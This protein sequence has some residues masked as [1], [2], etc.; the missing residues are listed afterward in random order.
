[1]TL[2]NSKRDIVEHKVLSTTKIKT[3]S[4]WWPSDSNQ[5]M[6]EITDGDGKSQKNGVTVSLFI[7]YSK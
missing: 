3:N 1:M 7:P 5:Y 2:Y 4:L 6:S